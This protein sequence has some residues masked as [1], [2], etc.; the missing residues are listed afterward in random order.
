MTLLDR[1]L[2][3][4]LLLVQL[5]PND[6]M[7]CTMPVSWINAGAK[8][9]TTSVTAMRLSEL[10][11]VPD[12]QIC[13]DT[14]SALHHHA[15]GHLGPFISGSI[16]LAEL[17]EAVRD[18][19]SMCPSEA[20][21][22]GPNTARGTEEE[23]EALKIYPWNMDEVEY[24]DED[25]DDEEEEEDDDDF[26]DG[27]RWVHEDEYMWDCD[28][29]EDYDEDG[30]E[31]EEGDYD[32]DYPDDLRGHGG[33]G[34]DLEDSLRGIRLGTP[35][36]NDREGTAIRIKESQQGAHACQQNDTGYLLQVGLLPHP[37]IEAG[38]GAVTRVLR[39]PTRMNFQ[40]LA[41]TINTAFDWQGFHAYEF[42]L[43]KPCR[44]R[45]RCMCELCEPIVA[46]FNQLVNGVARVDEWAEQFYTNFDADKVALSD[47]WGQDT[48]RGMNMWYRYDFGANWQHLIHFLGEADGR[49]GP[50]MALP[51][52]QEI[53]CLSGEGHPWPEDMQ[54]DMIQWARRQDTNLFE[55]DREAINKELRKLKI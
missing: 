46:K 27:G 54:E 37:M 6:T 55:W 39:V 25:G 51:R 28:D 7:T 45:L 53:W 11:I 40:Q 35:P 48:C 16:P 32:E 50:A 18:R 24:D 15:G 21:I 8:V 30:D 4:P 43:C 2:W 47:V 14:L 10:I 1:L 5:G 41:E 29:E 44:K 33:H 26:D 34:Q 38:P 22:L 36:T 19:I 20:P 9:S 31:N 42:K 13:D 3:L 23:G 12:V 52:S 17:L 49:L